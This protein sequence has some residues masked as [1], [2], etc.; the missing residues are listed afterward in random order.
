LLPERQ[1]CFLYDIF[2]YLLVPGD[3]PGSILKVY[4]PIVYDPRKLIMEK[5]HG[6]ILAGIFL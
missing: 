3:L 6:N 4:C 2:S 5:M 1:K